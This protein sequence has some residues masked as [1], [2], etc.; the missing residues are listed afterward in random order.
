[1]TDRRTS[2]GNTRN[3]ETH[4]AILDAAHELLAEHGYAG[5]SMEAV[6]RRA[7]AGKPTLYR[8]WPSKTALLIEL[9][10]RE[11]TRALAEIPDLGSAQK[12]LVA[13]IKGVHRFWRKTPAGQAFRSIIAEAQADDA[14]LRSLR[15]EFL[16]R[17]RATATVILDRAQARGEIAPDADRELLLDVLFGFSWYRLLTH[18]LRD[19]TGAVERLVAALLA[20]AKARGSLAGD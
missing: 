10:E 7:G 18:R 15:D 5:V 1:M 20:A 11:K 2:I 8:W 13:L 12:E 3:P 14:A 16:P 6:A 9:Y 4:A 17:G 19:D